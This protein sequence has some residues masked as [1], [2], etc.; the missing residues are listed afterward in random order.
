M[1]YYNVRVVDHW[2]R[3]PQSPP[4]PP[5][6]TH[7]LQL[8]GAKLQV[9]KPQLPVTTFNRYQILAETSDEIL[10]V[11]LIGDSIICE[12]IVEFCV[13]DLSH[14]KRHYIS[15]APIND[16]SAAYKDITRDANEHSLFISHADT[17][18]VKSSRSEALSIEISRYDK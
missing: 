7:S 10:E 6:L 9:N 14:R 8:G 4:L 13:R 17:N 3:L 15:G 5:P 1:S 12:Q 16:I 18:D 2:N 11:K